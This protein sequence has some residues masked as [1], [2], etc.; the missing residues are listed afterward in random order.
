[1]KKKLLLYLGIATY[2]FFI[3]PNNALSQQ[4]QNYCCGSQ[5][6]DDGLWFRV[7]DGCPFFP[8]PDIWKFSNFGTNSARSFGGEQFRFNEKGLGIQVDSWV[9]L[10]SDTGDTWYQIGGN[11]TYNTL[12]SGRIRSAYPV[13]DSLAYVFIENWNL[14]QS[15]VVRVEKDTLHLVSTWDS[16]TT[17]T[18]D[19]Y[20]D[21]SRLHFI[22]FIND[23]TGF[24]LLHDTMDKAYLKMTVDSGNSWTNAL[25]DSSTEFRSLYFRD[26]LNGILT[27]SNKI[28]ETKDAGISWT[29]IPSPSITVGVYNSV[30]FYNDSIG[31]LAT[32]SGFVMRTIDRGLNWNVEIDSSH[33]N[34]GPGYPQTFEMSKLIDEEIAYAI[35]YY[36]VLRRP[37]LTT[38]LNDEEYS[39]S[40]NFLVYPNPSDQYIRTI[41]P[42]E[43]PNPEFRIY[44]MQ[45]RLLLV[46]TKQP[47]NVSNLEKGTYI[48]TATTAKDFLRTT[49]IKDE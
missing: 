9:Y 2:F 22:S 24:V 39:A 45:G 7:I 29:L 14:K 40:A 15:Y 12:S 38:E 30:M 25:V 20:Y 1:M 37:G 13:H 49:F 10:T 23:S 33:R 35:Y 32:D 26:S 19:Y 16:L 44:D 34:I 48:I 17:P 3:S 18:K 28:Y 42:K 27:A 46:D 5:V 6:V 36:E 4:W 41:L 43:I 21:I 47:I 8:C 31:Y 11:Y